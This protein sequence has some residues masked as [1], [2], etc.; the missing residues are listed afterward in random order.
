MD[1]IVRDAHHLS[2]VV[3]RD[4]LSVRMSVTL[5]GR[6]GRPFDPQA[7]ESVWPEMGAKAG[8]PVIGHYSLGLQKCTANGEIIP[9]VRPRVITS[10][11]LREIDSEKA[12]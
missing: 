10:A 9:L 1:A 3:K 6:L 12:E 5:G 11:L 4:I 2:L 7:E 8:D